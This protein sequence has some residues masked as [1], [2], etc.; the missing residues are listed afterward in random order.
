MWEEGEA[1]KEILINN[2]SAQIAST[3][4]AKDV[5][6]NSKIRQKQTMSHEKSR[7]GEF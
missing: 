5:R 4:R 7:G 2:Y 6:R 1:K 3:A